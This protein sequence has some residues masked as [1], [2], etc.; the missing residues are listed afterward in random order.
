MGPA[1]AGAT[2]ILKRPPKGIGLL[3]VRGGPRT[4][5]AFSLLE[6]TN[7]GRDAQRNQISLDDLLMSRENSRIKLENGVFVIY[8]LASTNGTF[9][10]GQKILKQPLKDHDEIKI[11]ETSFA[12][13]EVQTGEIRG[14]LPLPST[15]MDNVHFSVSSPPTVVAGASF[16]VEVWAHLA[17][18]RSAVLR[19]VRASAGSGDVLLHSRGPVKVARGTV[20]TVQMAVEGLLLD[21]AQDTIFWEGEIGNAQFR[22]HVPEDALSGS[23]QGMARVYIDGLQIARIYFAI[24]I[25]DTLTAP[26]ELSAR[27]ERHRRAFASYASNDRDGV[28]A[29]VQGMQKV[30]PHLDIFLDVLSLRSGQDWEHELTTVIPAS[31]VFY[32]F[33]SEHARRSTWVEKEWRCALSTRGL[34]FI[35]PVPLSPPDV[36]P[37]PPELAG[38]HFNDWVLAFMRGQRAST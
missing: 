6:E 17:M 22:A 23:R 38:K 2:Q 16:L 35:D 5:Q 21:D 32:L 9:V 3:I 31:D 34:D 8:D 27:V 18:Q 36:A 13:V 1:P 12:F 28:L 4:G 29:R 10:N 7:I 30:M 25:G 19:R 37:P 11:G 24:E 26:D 33:W 15:M 14:S 20:L